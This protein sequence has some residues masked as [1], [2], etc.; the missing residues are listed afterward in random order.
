MS[1]SSF[2]LVCLGHAHLF[3][4]P[5]K[6]GKKKNIQKITLHLDNSK[7]NTH[8]RGA[9]CKKKKNSPLFSKT[10]LRKSVSFEAKHSNQFL[11]Y[12]EY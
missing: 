6:Q 1:S 5:H 3:V 4:L 11:I 10:L 9:F 8:Y 12:V 2:F 7:T